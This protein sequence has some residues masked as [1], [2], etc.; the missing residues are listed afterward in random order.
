MT[1][2]I[3]EQYDCVY[4]PGIEQHFWVLARNGIIY[5]TLAEAG[6]TGDKLIDI[7]CGR[8]IVVDYLRRHGV[9][10]HGSELGTPKLGESLAPYISTGI[11]ATQLPESLRESI[12]G[13]LLL[14]VIE[15]VEEVPAFLS[16]L[17]GAFPNAERFFITVPAHQEL[18]SH[19]DEQYGHYRRYTPVTLRA[20]VLDAGFR[21]A[22]L[23]SFFHG[24]YVPMRLLSLAGIKRRTVQA[25]PGN[26]ALH[27]VIAGFFR[28]EAKV[29][30]DWMLG[31]S[32]GVI[33]DVT[34]E[35]SHRSAGLGTVA[36]FAAVR[37]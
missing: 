32:L 26:P 29:L 13:I 14:D 22:R 5:D 2:F 8:G 10:C 33:A 4:P 23:R 30:P 28:W 37:S 19:W 31:T 11:D 3:Q 15:H 35:L 17:A 36:P 9:D 34:G 21:P 1:S 12:R 18:W 16:R 25:A 7:G 27:G 6:M 20:T 24:I